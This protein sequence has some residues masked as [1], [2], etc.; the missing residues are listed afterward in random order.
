MTDP[1]I[2]FVKVVL[3]ESEKLVKALEIVQTSSKKIHKVIKQFEE[4][5]HIA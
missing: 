1:N 5:N 3:R 4:Y 2:L